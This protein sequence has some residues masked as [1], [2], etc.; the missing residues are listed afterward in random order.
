MVAGMHGWELCMCPS[1]HLAHTLFGGEKDL[2]AGLAA[3]MR[4]I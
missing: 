1:D 2:A 3:L 4:S